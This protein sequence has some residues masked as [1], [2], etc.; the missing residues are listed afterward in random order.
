VIVRAAI[1]LAQ[2]LNLDVVAEGVETAEQLGLLRSWGCRKIQGYYFSQALP[3][4]DLEG[5]L[6]A[7]RFAFPPPD[8]QPTS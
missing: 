7:G 4:G 8:R 5:P 6:R 2:E 3:A 1:A